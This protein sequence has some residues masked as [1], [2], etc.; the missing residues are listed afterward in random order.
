M[1]RRPAAPD[2]QQAG[3]LGRLAQVRHRARSAATDANK[4]RRRQGLHQLASA[5]TRWTWAKGGQI[6][7]RK[8]VREERRVQGAQPET[9]RSPP[10]WT[11]RTSR[12]RLPGIGDVLTTV[13]QRVQRGGDPRQEADP[14]RRSDDG[15]AKANKHPRGQ[16]QEV[17]ELIPV[18]DVIDVGAARGDAPPP[19]A[20]RSPPGRLGGRTGR[21]TPYL[22]LAP[23]LVL[24]VGV[25]ACCRRLGLWI[26]LHE[27]DYL[28][29]NKPFVGLDNYK[30]PVLQ[31]LRRLRR[32]LAEHAGHGDLHGAVG[33]AA[34]GRPAG[35]GAAAE[36]DV[37]GPDVLPG[38]LLRAVRA[39]RRGGRPALAVPARR[40]PRPGQPTTSAC[41][42]CRRD[43]RL[44]DR[45]CRGPGSRWSG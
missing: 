10:S 1:G 44:D 38:G 35:V 37:P 11:T 27:W 34:G 39:G 23:Y 2:R 7:A 41:S 32:L 40:Q 12:R 45:R 14:G 16:P 19:A 9:R 8:A 43:T 33:A 30:R 18:A 24:F 20:K 5:S 22:F 17:R 13:L 25:R 42:G 3:R 29:P 21:A 15:A 4:R 26:S 28:L 36:P 31:R 6:P